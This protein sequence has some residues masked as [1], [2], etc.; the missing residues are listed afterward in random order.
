[1]ELPGNHTTV[2]LT[3][4]R[5]VQMKDVFSIEKIEVK[6]SQHSRVNKLNV[7]YSTVR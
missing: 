6:L 5:T 4:Y 3:L 1:M 7:Q 2:R